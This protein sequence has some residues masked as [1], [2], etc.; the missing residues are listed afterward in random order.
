MVC[1]SL[2]LLSQALAA[3][4]VIMRDKKTAR[5]RMQRAV[6]LSQTPFD[7]KP[8]CKIVMSAKVGG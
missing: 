2:P 1:L 4:V 7:L 3:L 5:G 6:L 8:D